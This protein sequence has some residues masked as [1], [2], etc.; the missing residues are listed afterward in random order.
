MVVKKEG[1]YK[2]TRAEK[3]ISQQIKDFSNVWEDWK[4][5][6]EES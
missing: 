5:I 2:S 6:E 3:M 4:Q 1:R